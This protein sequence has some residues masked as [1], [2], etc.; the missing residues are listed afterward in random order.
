MKFKLVE[1]LVEDSDG[2][3]RTFKL[4]L[5]SVFKSILKDINVN[6]YHLHHI[7]GNRD[8]NDPSNLSLMTSHNHRSLHAKYRWA[9]KKNTGRTLE[10]IYRE[11]FANESYNVKDLMDELLSIL[12]K[13]S[14]QDEESIDE[15]N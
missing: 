11:E 15:E 13:E 14:V 3:Q 1:N 12:A 4:F 2:G 5:Q 9:V 6:D 10:S 7:N 8:I